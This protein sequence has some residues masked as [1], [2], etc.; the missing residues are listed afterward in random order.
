[1]KMGR[2]TAKVSY[3]DCRQR[4]TAPAISRAKRVA[5]APAPA[6]E[7]AVHCSL[8]ADQSVTVRRRSDRPCPKPQCCNATRP[9]NSPQLHKRLSNAFRYLQNRKVYVICELVVFLIFVQTERK[10]SSGRCDGARNLA[11]Q[12]FFLVVCCNGIKC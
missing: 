8:C 6:A 2:L 3:A 7:R 4:A 12:V 10:R 9:P 11:V 1:M 5:A